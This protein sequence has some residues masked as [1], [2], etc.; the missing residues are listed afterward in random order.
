MVTYRFVLRVCDERAALKLQGLLLKHG[1]SILMVE[2]L[3]DVDGGP[4]A[5]A[6]ITEVPPSTHGNTKFVRNQEIIDKYVA[7]PVG[8]SCPKLAKE[9]GLSAERIAQI[10]RRPNVIAGAQARRQAAREALAAQKDELSAEARAVM[11]QA[12]ERGIELVRGGMSI[13]AAAAACGY[14]THTF[15]NNLGSKCRALKITLTHSRWQDFTER[16]A[17]VRALAAE[18]LSVPKIVDRLRAGPDP[19]MNAVWIYRNMPEVKPKNRAAAP[20]RSCEN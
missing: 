11:E 18:G 9:Y 10:L 5:A 8:N 16:K 3:P 15:A 12:L 4:P 7:D 17:R 14:S 19:R 6:P 1:A 2:T 13:S 20:V